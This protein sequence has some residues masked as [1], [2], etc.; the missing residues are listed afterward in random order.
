MSFY[1]FRYNFLATGV[2]VAEVLASSLVGRLKL[3]NFKVKVLGRVEN[4]FLDADKFN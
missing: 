2:V 4:R 3:I 1:L